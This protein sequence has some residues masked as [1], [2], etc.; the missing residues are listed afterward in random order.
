MFISGGKTTGV[1]LLHSVE[2]HYVSNN[3]FDNPFTAGKHG[4]PVGGSQPIIHQIIQS[5][6][7]AV[8]KLLGL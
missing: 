8:G 6:A 1:D 5:L 3:G 2:I 7:T 4:P